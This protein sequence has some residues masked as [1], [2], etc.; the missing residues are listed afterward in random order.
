[1]HIKIVNQDPART[2][3]VFYE[4]GSFDKPTTKSSAATLG[5]NAETTLYI[6]ASRRLVIEEDADATI[7]KPKGA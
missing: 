5:P 1:M 4:D 3:K 6:H 2:A 7:P